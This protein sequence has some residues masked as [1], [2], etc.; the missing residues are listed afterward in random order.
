V[1]GIV[2]RVTQS[3][4]ERLTLEYWTKYKNVEAIQIE[5]AAGGKEFMHILSRTSN[6]SMPIWGITPGSES[7][8]RRW[9]M[10]LEPMFAHERVTLLD[11]E[12]ITDTN[13]AIFLAEV[14]RALTRYPDI[15]KRGDKAADILDAIYYAIYHAL[16]AFADPVRHIQPT[17][18]KK[19]PYSGF[20]ETRI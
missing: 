4:A 7:K 11:K 8:E 18:K 19:N 1:D 6:F 13:Q 12:Q 2:A 14:E 15:R 20:I 17:S 10:N 9:E 5:E 3:Q 16:I